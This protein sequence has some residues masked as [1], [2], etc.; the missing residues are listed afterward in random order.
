[1][2]PNLTEKQIRAIHQ[3]KDEW[4]RT[5]GFAC[6]GEPCTDFTSV[7]AAQLVKKGLLVKKT[8]Y[9]ML[10]HGERLRTIYEPTVTLIDIL[11]ASK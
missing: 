10:D 6:V 8:D 2:F 11:E 3:I 7:V 9:V 5:I 1:M 4:F